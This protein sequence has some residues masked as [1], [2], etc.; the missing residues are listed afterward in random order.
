MDT[1]HLLRDAR[2]AAGL[3]QAELAERAGTSQATLSAYE[4][5]RKV[6]SVSTLARL[7]AATGRRLATAPASAPVVSPSAAK[8]AERGRIL[9]D[10]LDLASVL[11]GRK[12]KTLRFPALV[13]DSHTR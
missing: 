10:V 5:G 7:L 8:L 9:S 1:G 11:P 6:P 2:L 4:R 12:A 3:T 13:P